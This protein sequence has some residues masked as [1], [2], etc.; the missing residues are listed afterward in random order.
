MEYYKSNAIYEYLLEKN[1]PKFR[2]VVGNAWQLVYGNNKCEPLL[3]VFAMGVSEKNLESQPTINEIGGFNLLNLVSKKADI[4][5]LYLRFACDIENVTDVVIC[6]EAL[7]YEKISLQELSERYSTYGLPISK[8]STNKYLNDKTSS[9]YHNWQ[10]SNLGSS[11]TVSDI[12]LW[13]IDAD[14]NPEIIFELK[15][16]YYDLQRWQPFRDDFNNFKLI[17]NLCNR[18]GIKFKILYNQRTKNPFNDKID[19]LKLF[20]V[21]FDNSKPISAQGIVSLLEFENI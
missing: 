6:D 14:G 18:S 11:L 7:N 5:I 10:R 9:A 21:N 12:D 16:S 13:K 3:L 15:R 19:N 17:S 2:F 8:S 1:V 20:D 4:P